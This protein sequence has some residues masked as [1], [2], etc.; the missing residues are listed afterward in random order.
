MI[1]PYLL[2]DF[3]RSTTLEMSLMFQEVSIVFQWYFIQFLGDNVLQAFQKTPWN[4]D[5][6][7]KGLSERNPS[8][9]F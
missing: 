3:Q 8:S 9:P 2:Y 4:V 6:I 1:L 5:W 7:E